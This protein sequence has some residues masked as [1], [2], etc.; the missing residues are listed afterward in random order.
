MICVCLHQVPVAPAAEP[1]VAFLV[2]FVQN[3]DGT[4]HI[5][6]CSS[7]AV[8]RQIGVSFS[9]YL[10][11]EFTNCACT[12]CDRRK[13]RHQQRL[14]LRQGKRVKSENMLLKYRTERKEEGVLKIDVLGSVA[15]RTWRT[16]HM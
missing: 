14:L 9:P 5:R 1:E 12:F 15:C 6:S 7:S 10:D 3:H 16:W 11:S 8:R 2:H 4:C 13:L